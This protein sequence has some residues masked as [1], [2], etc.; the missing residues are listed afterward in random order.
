MALPFIC[1]RIFPFLLH[2]KG[3]GSS[4]SPPKVTDLGSSALDSSACFYARSSV[5]QDSQTGAYGNH[6][7]RKGEKVVFL[8]TGN[9]YPTETRLAITRQS[10]QLRV[11]GCYFMF[12]GLLKEKVEGRRIIRKAFIKQGSNHHH[13]WKSGGGGEHN[14][15]NESQPVFYFPA[16]SQVMTLK[17]AAR[18]LNVNKC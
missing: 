6:A 3:K 13:L 9:P 15:H 14:C 8:R 17:I 11:R 18:G 10:L 12:Y 7:L 5:V 1:D 2:F 16:Q 4:S